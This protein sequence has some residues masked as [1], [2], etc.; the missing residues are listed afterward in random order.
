MGSEADASPM[1][2]EGK[3]KPGMGDARDAPRGQSHG[4]MGPGAQA[5]AAAAAAALTAATA[6][7][8]NEVKEDAS[9]Y[10]E[11]VTSTHKCTQVQTRARRLVPPGALRTRVTAPYLSDCVDDC[12]RR[13]HPGRPG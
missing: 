2:G 8:L 6:G 4:P 7:R 13:V 1:A 9:R 10:G 5:A 12:G 11:L 3:L